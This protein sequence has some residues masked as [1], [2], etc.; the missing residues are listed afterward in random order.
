MS[1]RPSYITR[2]GVAFDTQSDDRVARGFARGMQQ[3]V[4]RPTGFVRRVFPTMPS[5]LQ[6]NPNPAPGAYSPPPLTNRY[7]TPEQQLA[8]S[9]GSGSVANVT[10]LIN[11]GRQ[12]MDYVGEA[13]RRTPDQQL[14]AT[15]G[16]GAVQ[17]VSQYME[18]ARDGR[19]NPY[20]GQIEPLALTSYE[21]ALRDAPD[22][23]RPVKQNPDGTWEYGPLTADQVS[24]DRLAKYLSQ[25]SPVMGLDGDPESRAANLAATYPGLAAAALDQGVSLAD[26]A[27]IDNV[28]S[29]RKAADA[30]MNALESGDDSR[31]RQLVAANTPEQQVLIAAFISDRINKIEV[32]RQQAQDQGESVFVEI[33]SAVWNVSAGPVFDFLIA[34][35][36]LAQHVVRTTMMS[37][38]NTGLVSLGEPGSVG[39]L[40]M[41]SWQATAPGY[42]NPN[43]LQRL[44]NEYGDLPVDIM[45]RAYMVRTYG[46][47]DAYDALLDEY[48]E[49][50]EAMRIIMAGLNDLNPAGKAYSSLYAEVAGLDQGNTGNLVARGAGLNPNTGLFEGLRDVSNITSVFVFDPTILGA[51]AL[52]AYRF[53]KYG[54]HNLAGTSNINKAFDRRATRNWFDWYGGEVQRIQNITDATERGRQTTTLLAQSRKYANAETLRLFREHKIYNAD[55]AKEFLLGMETVERVMVG[56]GA[57]VRRLGQAPRAGRKIRPRVQLGGFPIYEETGRILPGP[58]AEAGAA[59]QRSFIEAQ[60]ARRFVQVYTPHMMT[61]TTVAKQVV[62]QIRLNGDFSGRILSRSTPAMDNV[63]GPEYSTLPIDRQIERFNLVLQDDAAVQILARELGDFTG[64]RTIVAK[65]LDSVVKDPKIRKTLGLDKKGWQRKGIGSEGI[66]GL[67]QALARKVDRWAGLMARMPDSRKPIQWSNAS[68]ADRIYQ[69]MRQAGVHRGAAS[70]FR[71]MWIGMNEA[72]RRTAYIGIIKMYGRA[73]GIDLVDPKNGMKNLLEAVT[74]IRTTELHAANQIPRFGALTREV[75]QEAEAVAKEIAKNR[76]VKALGAREIAGLKEDILARR[77]AEGE[78]AAI[79]PS[80]SNSISNAIW[81]GQTSEFGF[82]PNIGALDA[83]T[84][85]SSMLNALLFNN[86]AG[87]SITDWWVLGTLAGPRFQLR[88]G[89]EEIG[90]YALTG[91]SFGGFWTGRAISTGLR[92]GTERLSPEVVAAREAVKRAKQKLDDASKNNPTEMD[93]ARLEGELNLAKNDLAEVEKR[94]GGRGKKLGFVKT[95]NRKAATAAVAKLERD[96]RQAKAD[97]LASWWLPFLSK[98]EVSKAARLAQSGAP[99]AEVRKALAQMQSQAVARQMLSVIRDP[100]AR[101]ILPLLK[102]GASRDEMSERQRQILDWVDDL[103]RSRYGI[104]YQD[105]A[106]ETARHFADGVMPAVDDL[107]D[108]SVIDGELYR[109]VTLRGAYESEKVAGRVTHKQAEAM[110][111]G[112][113]MAV[114]DGPRGQAALRQLPKFWYAY[115][116]TPGAPDEKAMRDAVASVQRAMDESDLAPVYQGRLSSAH[117]GIPNKP[118]EDVLMTLTGLFTTPSGKFNQALWDAMKSQGDKGGTVFKLYDKVDGQIVP[119]ISADDL[120]TGKYEPSANLLVYNAERYQVPVKMNFKDRT[121]A[122]MGRSF[123]RMVREPIWGSNYIDARRTFLPMQ[124]QWERLFGKERAAQMAAD[125][126]A[127]RAYHLT[128]AYGDNP[129]VRTK[130]AWEVRNIARFYRAIEDFGRRMWRT[131]R[132]NP[133]AFWKASLAWNASLDTGWVFEDE[134]GEAYF[135]YPG[136]KAAINVM[137][138]LMNLVGVGMK[139]P[140]LEM[141]VSGKV[142]WLTPSADPESWLPTLSGVWAGVAYRPLLRSLPT[143]DG[144]TKEI[145]KV[146]FGSI[147]AE[148]TLQTPLSGVPIAGE[149]A[150]ALP[151]TLPPILNKTLLGV[152]P[153][154]FGNDLPGSF[155]SRQVMKAALAMAANGDLPSADLSADEKAEYMQRLDVTASM[156]SIASILF[157]L[158]APAAPQIGTAEASQFARNIGLSG[159]SPAFQ[160]L[161]RK[162]LEKEDGSIETA[163]AKFVYQNPGNSPFTLSKS[164]TG[165]SGFLLA[166]NDNQDFIL[167]NEDLYEAYPSGMAFFAPN[168]GE[169]VLAASRVLGA[170]GFRSPKAGSKYAEE[171]LTQQGYVEWRVLR[172]TYDDVIREQGLS[173][174][175]RKAAD[176]AYS[177]LSKRLHLRYKGLDRRTQGGGRQVTSEFE[178]SV[179]QAGEVAEELAKRGNDRAALFLPVYDSYLMAKQELESF[180]IMS[181]DYADDRSLL[182]SAWMSYIWQ[183]SIKAPADEQWQ[184]LLYHTTKAIDSSWTMPITDPDEVKQ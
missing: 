146:V 60:G 18:A 182:K 137:N 102:R 136:S 140:D 166:T 20:T 72:Q 1:K 162:E 94:F 22:G 122:T 159:L 16:A 170:L 84:A 163:M 77:I 58:N 104:Q 40:I 49:D 28:M 83:I 180:N 23:L 123:A 42:M 11:L 88:N 124:R 37:V 41:A 164:E 13:E 100:D 90:L 50:P 10:E 112:L 54:I 87:S 127:E 39:D 78:F 156:L 139:V 3:R 36:D 135:I 113:L 179:R 91:G 133:L 46:D 174:D 24:Q 130:L 4:D 151:S 171:L 17:N 32:A 114:T 168:T 143:M 153:A 121:W 51:K 160:R 93:L 15:F 81:L 69:L 173:S 31:A 158:N 45:V 155:A 125:A 118:A 5:Q 25:A 178:A 9:V 55:E 65:V 62:R 57:P 132:N 131:G 98:E 79:N 152:V 101:G 30:A 111:V 12:Q 48:G 141:T 175:D 105:D 147:S 8:R 21:V 96:G 29:A 86:R 183:E 76:G 14:A 128:M 145:E 73:A 2:Y 157:G 68:D 184:R 176:D 149:V 52:A 165:D 26:V 95:L 169:N 177:A 150:S 115:N 119:R 120:M 64:Q 59:L 75:E 116:K 53:A 33:G 117:S 27:D 7:L 35:N 38:Q 108:T 66:T 167:K 67:P 34:A 154:F 61:S 56:R 106:A 44:R 126:S 70:E 97:A 85:R 107:G 63:L 74:G 71:S 161:L 142:Q 109:N 172:A 89:V 47:D 82:F 6:S 19:L 148:Q 134:Y 43:D 181:A 92:E 99:D 110:Y 144:L 138:D 129:A 103:T 80:V